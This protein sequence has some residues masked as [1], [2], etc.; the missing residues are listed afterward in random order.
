MEQR[1]AEIKAHLPLRYANQQTEIPIFFSK[2]TNCAEQAHIYFSTILK[3][4]MFNNFMYKRHDGLCG[5][6]NS[7]TT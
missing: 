3:E 2:L 5:M 1:L 7:K 6:L 4:P